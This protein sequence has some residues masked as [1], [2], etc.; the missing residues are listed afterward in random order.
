M[1]VPGF[2]PTCR[3]AVS[4]N[5]GSAIGGDFAEMFF[6]R[7]PDSRCVKCITLEP[8]GV[9]IFNSIALIHPGSNR[10][11][12]EFESSDESSQLSAELRGGPLLLGAAAAAAAAEKERPDFHRPLPIPPALFDRLVTF[13][14]ALSALV[15]LLTFSRVVRL[16]HRLSPP[17]AAF[18]RGAAVA[19]LPSNAF[20]RRPDQ[21]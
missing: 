21:T 4:Q 15:E 18:R 1:A 8:G 5:V 12:T 16:K 6:A 14:S 13:E 20:H 3:V 10:V 7:S 2:A 9:T 19:A 17:F 11:L